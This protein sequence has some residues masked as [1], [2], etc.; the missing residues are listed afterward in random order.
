MEYNKILWMKLGNSFFALEEYENALFSYKKAL[1]YDQNNKVR[2]KLI[3]KIKRVMDKINTLEKEK[4]NPLKASNIIIIE[5]TD[6]FNGLQFEQL[7]KIL[8]MKMG[9]Q[10]LSTS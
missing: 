5:D 6:N 10:V 3:R 2:I 4:L 9:Y 8:F 7:L 1:Y